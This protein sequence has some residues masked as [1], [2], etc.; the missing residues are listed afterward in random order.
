MSAIA[1]LLLDQGHTIS[2]SDLSL[3]H[4]TEALEQR[5]A[6]IH[7]GHDPSYVAGADVLLAT[8]AVGDNHPE[9]VAARAAGIPVLRRPDI[10]ND[11]S[12][13]R[14]IIGIAGTHGKT[15]TTAMLSLVLSRAGLDIGFLVGAEFS[16]LP[17]SARWGS[18]TAPL[19]IEA[20]EYDQAFLGLH[21]TIG[22]VTHMEWDH[23]DTYQS[24]AAYTAAFAAFLHQAQSLV[25]VSEQAQILKGCQ[26][27]HVRV[28]TYGLGTDNDYR[29]VP[30]PEAPGSWLVYRQGTPTPLT[31]LTL[32]V[33]G[34]HNVCNALA[35]LCVTD[36]LELDTA[37]AAH[38]LA[39]FRGAAR[40]F[41]HKG[42][43]GTITVID[44]YAHHPTETVATLAAARE[45]Y[46]QRRVVAYIQPHTF[47]RTL[48][49]LDDWPDALRQADV[50]CVGAIYPSREKAP[51]F[52]DEAR[53]LA[54]HPIQGT[55]GSANGREQGPAPLEER[56]SQELAARI[57]SKHPQAFYAGTLRQA[58]ATIQSLLAPGDVLITMG[59]GDGF[60]IGEEIVQILGKQQANGLR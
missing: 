48:A 32:S 4:I 9:L 12:H 43:V 14:S 45:R 28:V 19:V 53:R 36:L 31:T 54:E 22:V 18:P 49:L 2:G 46:G 21:P 13:T 26:T 17:T 55:D 24:S 42:D 27:D 56:L 58:T 7:Q 44:D 5:G 40:R 35:A 11:W 10:W 25:V 3:N 41:E 1:A 51:A 60:R 52:E 29:A 20:D 50:V 39:H 8:S 23:P 16:Q 37:A 15:T 30:S 47:S 59:A 38:T 57:A 34:E 33:P 6:I